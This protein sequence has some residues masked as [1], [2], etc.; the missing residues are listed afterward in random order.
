MIKLRQIQSTNNYDR[1][2]IIRNGKV[3]VDK[4]TKVPYPCDFDKI[5]PKLLNRLVELM[6]VTYAKM[7]THRDEERGPIRIKL[8]N[9]ELMCPSSEKKFIG[10]LPMGSYYTLTDHDNY[11]GIYWRN[12]WGTHDFDL[13][14][15]VNGL[16]IGWNANYH[17]N[18]IIFSGDMTNA[19]PEATEVL[20]IPNDCPNGTIYVN[21][22][23][24]CR[25][26]QFRLF[27]GQ[28]KCEGFGRNY[29]VDPNSIILEDTLISDI[30]EQMVGQVIDNKVYF[31]N[32]GTGDG[33][34]SIVKDTNYV[35]AQC[36]SH[37]PL[38]PVLEAVGYEI[39][40]ENPDIDLSVLS[41]EGLLKLFI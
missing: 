24:G 20:Y 13:S 9:C 17:A 3:W 30:R 27:F 8:P 7:A 25:G 2:F 1:M 40:T 14:L 34:V 18:D 36:E 35:K 23:N 37:I 6:K 22:Y 12:E 33:R 41:K 4:D 16:K 31:L 19:E 11:F 10:N 28:D 39:V 29:M 32:L 26:S 38:R 5:G 15:V 21:R